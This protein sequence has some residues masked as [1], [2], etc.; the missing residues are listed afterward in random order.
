ML[1]RTE[2]RNA[3]SRNTDRSDDWPLSGTNAGCPVTNYT[4]TSRSALHWNADHDAQTTFRC[5]LERHP[6]I[7]LVEPFQSSLQV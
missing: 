7:T 4:V 5:I 6:E 2:G 1:S 3:D